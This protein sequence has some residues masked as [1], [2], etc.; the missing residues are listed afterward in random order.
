VAH[1]ITGRIRL[2]FATKIVSDPTLR[3]LKKRPEAWLK[4]IFGIDTL[5]AIDGR[6]MVGKPA[7]VPGLKHL[8]I[9]LPGQALVVEYD[10]VVWPPAWLDELMT[11][12]DAKRIQSLLNTMAEKCVMR[13]R[14]N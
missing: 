9:N 5:P 4:A 6:A 13:L 14:E 11:S 2:R 1:H 12:K 3:D 7:M 10:P 8:R